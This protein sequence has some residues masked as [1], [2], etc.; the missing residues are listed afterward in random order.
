LHEAVIANRAELKI[1]EKLMYDK[2]HKAVA[3]D[4]QVND[5]VLLK[6]SRIRPGALKVVIRQR[7]FGP[8][9]IKDVINRRPDVGIAH[10]LVE[11]KTGKIFKNLVTNDRLKRY[12][13]DRMTFSQRLLR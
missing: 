6:D 13:V 5:R 3:S 1:E 7:F 2:A 4:W 11:E 12:N 9:V 10:Q 8:Y